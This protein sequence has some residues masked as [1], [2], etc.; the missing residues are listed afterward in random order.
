MTRDCKP[1]VEL[2]VHCLM[3]VLYTVG[4]KGMLMMELCSL[5]G[6]DNPIVL[7]RISY[8]MHEYKLT[9]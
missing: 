2:K 8:K 5:G 7:T 6:E 3:K 9:N 4:T 1:R